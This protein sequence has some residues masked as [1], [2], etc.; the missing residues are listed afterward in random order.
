[1]TNDDKV[2]SQF[3]IEQEI[4]RHPNLLISYL[5]SYSAADSLKKKV[6]KKQRKISELR[7]GMRSVNVRAKVIDVPPMRLVTTRFGNQSYVSNVKIADETGSINL[8]L[9]NKQIEKVHV[10][11]EIDI[12]N[13]YVSVFR[14]EPQLR[15][16][17][18][19]TISIIEQAS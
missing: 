13:C 12:K 19:G 9:W 18:K 3:P 17:R 11:D 6:E 2:I 1:V 14:D 15:I 5:N 10:G 8:S 7:F 16:G 4:L